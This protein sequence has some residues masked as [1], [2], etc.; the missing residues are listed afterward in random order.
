[1]VA[2]LDQVWEEVDAA[3]KAVPIHVLC[4]VVVVMVMMVGAGGVLAEARARC[5]AWA[6][7][8]ARGQAGGLGLARAQ[9]RT[10]SVVTCAL[11]AERGVDGCGSGCAP[12]KLR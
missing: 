6:R 12:D 1:M 9:A 8:K 2:L 7:G 10:L 11:E 4:E 3:S 5:R